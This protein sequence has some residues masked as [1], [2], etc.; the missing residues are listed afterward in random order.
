M[1]Y[2]HVDECLGGV[3]TAGRNV[4]SGVVCTPLDTCSLAGT[5]GVGGVCSNPSKPDGASCDDG[6][7]RTLSDTCSAGVCGLVFVAFKK[8]NHVHHAQ[9]GSTTASMSSVRRRP[10]SAS[11][12]ACAKDTV[13]QT[14][15]LDIKCAL[16]NMLHRRL[17]V[18]AAAQHHALQ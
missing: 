10:D 17:R 6:N 14:V 3:C 11:K 15:P 9:V 7:P 2:F 16:Q 1:S 18:P 5:C 4:C 12:Q 13:Y 8:V